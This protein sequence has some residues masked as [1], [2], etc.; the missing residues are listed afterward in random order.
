MACPPLL[1]APHTWRA[2]RAICAARARGLC[3]G[4]RL[5]L[6]DLSFVKPEPGPAEAEANPPHG[7]STTAT[8]SAA[9]AAGRCEAAAHRGCLEVEARAAAEQRGRRAVDAQ[10]RAAL[11]KHLLVK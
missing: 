3:G 4:M 5:E 8:A 10:L 2:V 11:R 6:D 9:A 1:P 7:S